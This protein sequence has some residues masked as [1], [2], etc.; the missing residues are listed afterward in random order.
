MLI[1]TRQQLVK[2]RSDSLL[3]GDTHVPPVNEARN[4]GV[5]FDSN[6]QFHSHINK[7][8]QSAFYSLY[9]ISRIRKYLPLEAA[10]TLVQAM[11]IN[12]ID[13]CNAILYGLPAI[14]IRKLQCVQ[15]A[16]ARLLANT[17][18]YSHIT[19]VMIDL[20]WLPVEF[21]IIFKMILMTFKPLHGLTPP[22]LSNMLSYKAHLR[23]N[24]RCDDSNMLVRPAIRSDLCGRTS[25]LE[26]FTT[27]PYGRG[28][29][30]HL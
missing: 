18:R 10:K 22:Y 26:Y 28:Q 29:Y 6:F 12:R 16:A 30:E 14:H 2:V 24:S 1:G 5:C 25:A 11:V 27:F 7:T 15:N 4:L 20:H 8:Y 9:N 13:Y 17:T 19:P 21:R 3:V 23:Y